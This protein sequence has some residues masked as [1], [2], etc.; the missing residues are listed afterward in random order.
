M[1]Q[2]QWTSE[3]V[4]C[5]YF[6]RK[7]VDCHFLKVIRHFI[8]RNK[9][10]QL[11]GVCSTHSL[12]PT[13]PW[14]KRKRS[15]RKSTHQTAMTKGWGSSTIRSI[16]SSS[17]LRILTFNILVWH[18]PC[19]TWFS[20]NGL[21]RLWSN[22]LINTWLI[23][24]RNQH[25]DKLSP[26]AFVCARYIQIDSKFWNLSNSLTIENNDINKM[27]LSSVFMSLP[28]SVITNTSVNFR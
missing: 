17:P 12:T 14:P 10:I 7:Q 22:H 26:P 1:Q 16:R 6:L 2:Q 8:F 13:L 18:Y 27:V 20:T 21:N 5:A 25:K 15:H 11:N 23:T 24:Q 4:G 28:P 3:C 9:K 19:S